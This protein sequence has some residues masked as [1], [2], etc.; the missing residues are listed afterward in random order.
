ME[1]KHISAGSR[2]GT[3]FFFAAQACRGRWDIGRNAGETDLPGITMK[4][5]P[6]RFRAGLRCRAAAGR[7]RF[8][9]P[10]PAKSVMWA[11]GTCSTWSG[12]RGWGALRAH[13]N[14]H[15]PPISRAVKTYRAMVVAYHPGAPGL[16]SLCKRT[17]KDTE[18][19]R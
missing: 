6:Q 2:C 4:A 18:I 8:P 1:G 5:S 9:I 7:L 12:K 10:Q 19:D 17:P 13:A 14:T 15:R 16:P 11:A 3:A